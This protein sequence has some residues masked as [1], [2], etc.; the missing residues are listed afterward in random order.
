MNI[1]TNA[2][3]EQQA[4]QAN[5]K[6]LILYDNPASGLEAE[7]SLK[8]AVEGVEEVMYCSVKAWRL[9]ALTVSPSADEA[10]MDAEDADLILFAVS[11]GSSF[12]EW[13]AEWLELWAIRR[14]VQDAT[15]AV[16]GGELGGS[17][18]T[19]GMLELSR[20]AGRHG[21]VVIFDDRFLAEDES[22]SSTH[23]LPSD[24]RAESFGRSTVQ[25]LESVEEAYLDST[26]TS[27]WASKH[28]IGLNR[29]EHSS[30]SAD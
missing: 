2:A 15:L 5:L 8:R 24:L 30:A 17:F 13:L 18:S 3:R 28:S 16:V 1:K 22:T 7:T 10:L 21:L 26:G 23:R 14:E 4:Y 19:P 20:I 25:H 11:Q 29:T 27:S 12:S 6:V 9:D